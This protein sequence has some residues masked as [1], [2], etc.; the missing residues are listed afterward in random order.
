MAGPAYQIRTARLL[1]RCWN[2]EDAPLLGEAVQAS[3]DHLIPWMPWAT[4]EPESLESRAQRLRGFRANFDLDQDYTYGIFSADETRVLGG[5]G[6]HKRVGDGAREIGY[7]IHA[8]DIGR[9]YATEA[10]AALTRVGFE[11]DG[12]RRIDIHCDPENVRS[13]AIPLKLGYSHEAT[14]RARALTSHNSPRDTMIWSMHREDY[15]RSAAAAAEV[16]ALDM[17][18]RRLL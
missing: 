6:L 14:L 11:V 2:P 13:A 15:P 5:T 18:G 1:L 3:L 7:W 16:I 12:L 9:G 17:L 8:N 10:T 4:N